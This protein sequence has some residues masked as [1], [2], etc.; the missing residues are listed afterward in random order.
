MISLR[1]QRLYLR[2]VRYDD[3]ATMYDYRNNELCA[4]YQRGQTKD[5]E[6]IQTLVSRRQN[7]T[8]SDRENFLVAVALKETDQL[9]GEIVVIPNDGCFS[10]GYTFH[11]AHHRKGY[12][13]E[14]LSALT[15]YLHNTYPQMEFISFTE[16]E[17]TASMNLLKKLGYKDLGYIPQV[18]SQMFG[19]WLCDQVT[20]APLR[21]TDED[22][23]IEMFV[24]PQ[25]KKTYMLPDFSCREEAQ[26]LFNRMQQMSRDPERFVIGIYAGEQLAGFMNETEKEGSSI[27]IGWVVHPNYQNRGFATQAAKLAIEALFA[28]GFTEVVAGAFEE[29]LASLRVMEK[30]GMTRLEKTD[31][32]DYRGKTHRCVYYSI[33]K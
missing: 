31:E 26:H 5:L 3:A 23:M 29:N 12:A 15:E 2:N 17:N 20:I 18:E 6:G 1:T 33:Q 13:F 21:D 9:V 14:A 11:Y 25:I 32:I 30:A 24:H 8:I 28:R 22:A 16:P 27:E 4:R 10:I 19:K 7:D